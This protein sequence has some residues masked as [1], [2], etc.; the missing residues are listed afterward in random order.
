MQSEI[1]L[2]NKGGQHNC[3]GP[4]ARLASHLSGLL[5][6]LGLLRAMVQVHLA[7]SLAVWLDQSP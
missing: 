1:S 5:W 6:L 3:N 4:C 7:L 2:R